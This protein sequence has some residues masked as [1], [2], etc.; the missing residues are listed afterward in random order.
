MYTVPTRER[1]KDVFLYIRQSTD[2]KAQRQVRSMK[3]QQSDCEAMAMH[4]GLNIVEVFREDKSAKAPHRRPVFKSMIKAL[5]YKTPAKR[6]ADGILSWHPNRLSRNALEA[7][8]VIQM[9]DDNL[10]KDMYFPAYSF[11]NDA[12]GKEHLFMEFARSKGYSDHLSVS[13]LRGSCNRERDGAMVYPVKFGFQK[14]REVPET[15]ALCSLFP[16]PCPTN[17][18]IVQ[19]IFELRGN[20]YSLADIEQFL[21]EEALIPNGGKLGKS[22]ISG[23]ICDQFYFGMWYINKGKTNERVINMREIRLPDGTEF[24]PILTESDFWKCQSDIIKNQRSHKRIKHINPIPV[25][26]LCERCG[27]KMRPCWKKVKRAGGILEPQLGYECQTR[28]DGSRCKQPRI[29]SDILYAHIAEAFEQITLDKRYYQ[30]FLVGS[31][32]FI[33]RKTQDLKRDRVKQ[34]KAIQKLK[35]QKLDLLR[36]KAVLSA[37]AGLSP[38]DKKVINGELQELA[39]L[40]EKAE[41]RRKDLGEDI[42][43]KTIGFKKFIELSQSLHSDWLEAD[44][45]QKQKISEKVVLNLTIENREI[46]SQTWSA[47]FQAWLNSH[48]FFDGRGELKN[49]EPY[50]IRLWTIMEQYP[51]FLEGWK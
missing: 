14:R 32:T 16:I 17:Y 48:K 33:R 8:I 9:L 12:S 25:P 39:T 4:L 27:G 42:R 23:I 35:G 44:L 7:G 24:E 49:L 40:I 46:R 45:G 34:T 2:E 36:Q 22:R 21:T 15:P 41:I 20:G 47:P 38:S 6:R 43:T 3:D 11:H 18:P 31:E 29:K 37:D 28:R 19:R 30:R 1:T 5:S 10:I 51:D 26:V 13:V 50:F